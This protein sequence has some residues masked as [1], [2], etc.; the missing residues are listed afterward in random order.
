MSS[1]RASLEGASFWARGAA[2]HLDYLIVALPL[3]GLEL[4][5][6]G[7]TL[8]YAHGIGWTVATSIGSMLVCGLYFVGF[9]Y[10][11]GAT[12]GKRL[13]GL[14]V[15]REDS[16][17][18]ASLL[19]LIVRYVG[20]FLSS[21]PLGLGF[22]WAGI[23]DKRQALH[24]K[25]SRTQVVCDEENEIVRPIPGLIG[26][27]VLI[28]LIS[29]FAVSVMPTFMV[30]VVRSA[31]AHLEVSE[32]TRVALDA[33][34]HPAMRAWREDLLSPQESL[35]VLRA[36]SE[37]YQDRQEDVFPGKGKRLSEERA[38][39][40]ARTIN[41][42]LRDN[43]ELDVPTL[44]SLGSDFETKKIDTKTNE[45]LDPSRV[46][47]YLPLVAGNEWQYS[48][49]RV[50]DIKKGDETLSSTRYSGIVTFKV[51]RHEVVEEGGRK[52]LVSFEFLE[53]AEGSISDSV[54]EI[55]AQWIEDGEGISVLA[56]W[57][58][59]RGHGHIGGRTDFE[60]PF[61]LLAQP[62]EVGL[63]WDAGTRRLSGRTVHF[64][65]RVMPSTPL[66]T[67]I[68]AVSHPLRIQ[69]EGEV[70]G[71][72]VVDGRSRTIKSGRWS[73]SEYYA[74]GV[75][76][77]FREA[78]ES[79]DLAGGIHVEDATTWRIRPGYVARQP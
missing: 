28:I 49:K 7:D 31:I 55:G 61:R 10:R 36:A 16:G 66:E 26:V 23:D 63:E 59:G 2:I 13:F 69:A 19:S 11:F 74:I 29:L 20:Y 47:G 1:A 12:P 76:L 25:I 5:L 62:I 56:E 68:G 53:S 44:S 72:Y 46:G 21:L 18:D 39:E 64:T 34:V 67:R 71:T 24:D 52:A 54:Y 51:R 30:W 48:L 38:L 17:D 3:F 60:P 42:I 4:L 65:R 15:V 41:R 50:L 9:W 45:D 27:S 73:Q 43:P 35:V 32:S 57:D 37:I 33:H 14:R 79:L 22:L 78:A 75:G 77:V 8:F 6:F 40:L 58:V 70:N